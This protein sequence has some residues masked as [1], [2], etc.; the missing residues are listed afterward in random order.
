[1]TDIY[2]A[3]APCFSG[4]RYLKLM[5]GRNVLFSF[6]EHRRRVFA[7]PEHFGRAILD[8]GAYSAFCGNRPVELRDYIAYLQY[9]KDRFWWYAALDVIG[10]GAQSAANWRTM[11]SE[12]LRPVPVFHS[13]E[14]FDLLSE[15]R[16]HTPLVA[17]GCEPRLGFSGRMEFYEEVFGRYP[18]RYHL[19]RATDRRIL[20]RFDAESADSATWTRAAAMGAIPCADG[21]RARADHLSPEQ[22]ASLW[23]RHFTGL[24]TE[25]L[26]IRSRNDRRC[27]ESDYAD[28]PA[29]PTGRAGRR[30]AGGANG[31][32][33]ADGKGHGLSQSGVGCALCLV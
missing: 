1:M 5:A 31:A 21:I 7:R 27:L 9:N 33:R 10:D 20:A 18:H 24:E 15:Y 28:D 3:G 16:A 17:L 26:Q 14:P 32:D 25:L 29:D 13:S 19:F 4:E 2:F 12:G 6:G 23:I 30:R 11:R 22:R 8:S